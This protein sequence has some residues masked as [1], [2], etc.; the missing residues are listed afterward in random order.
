MNNLRWKKFWIKFQ[1]DGRFSK[2]R[3]KGKDK[4]QLRKWTIRK[5]RKM[6]EDNED[7]MLDK[8]AFTKR[9]D[10]EEEV[11]GEQNKK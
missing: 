4:R 11:K 9:E 10:A 8:T 6:R 3:I 7:F 1:G 5:L 2:E